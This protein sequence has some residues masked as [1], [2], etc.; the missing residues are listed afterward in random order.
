MTMNS[1][2]EVTR[3]SL[4]SR[5]SGSIIMVPIGILLIIGSIILLSWNESR[6]VDRMRTLAEGRSLVVS[7]SSEVLDP[8]NNDAL[9]HMT[10]KASSRDI[11]NDDLF[12]VSV[13][14][15]L[16]RR[17]V[18]MYQWEEEKKSKTKTN[19]DG[20]KTTRTTYSYRKTWS[21]KIIDS[22][23]FKRTE[24]HENPGA[25]MY[26]SSTQR[27]EDVHVGAFTLTA[28]FVNQLDET[29]QYNLSEENY[30]DMDP[31]ARQFFQL[32]GGRL[33]SDTSAQPEIGALRV[34]FE[35]VEPTNVSVVGQQKEGRL[36][37]F[38]TSN[39]EIK[40]LRHGTMGI[41]QMF[42]AAELDNT[43]MTWGL[44][45]GGFVAMWF[46]ISMILGP[47]TLLSGLVP[48]VGTII[49]SGIALVSG[50]T[51][52]VFS[53]TII[54]LAWL[55][56]RPLIGGTIFVIIVFVAMGGIGFVN[57]RLRAGATQIKARTL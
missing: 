41:N 23:N 4:L 56:F 3:T 37:T 32:Q 52:F 22:T 17:I 35:I 47:I 30:A 10:G 2:T 40:M 43:L 36:E 27:A 15:I 1:F 54:M 48:I 7:V 44:R 29:G 5:L 49:N 53:G 57:R 21:P 39:G 50:L 13:N 12:G 8:R 20:S 55:S 46:G 14:A 6:A 45:L 28:P 31:Y 19:S 18:E 34:S 16:L 9:V 25:M 11:L 33:V 24:G 42:A 26:Q 51:A 38:Y